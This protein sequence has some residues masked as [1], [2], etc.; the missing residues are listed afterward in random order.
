MCC[1]DT[2][3]VM[4]EQTFL[5]DIADQ[6]FTKY[7][8][9]HFGVSLPKVVFFSLYLKYYLNL[10]FNL[11]CLLFTECP[12][13]APGSHAPLIYLLISALCNISFVCLCHLLFHLSF[14]L[15]FFLIYLL[16]YSSFPL[17]ID[18]LHFEVG[19]LRGDHTWAF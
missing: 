17:R 18:P 5:Q 15:H 10:A 6:N 2:K 9:N 11:M 3:S 12:V 8:V 14:F 19:G 4:Y 16:H 13:W 7:Q 1:V